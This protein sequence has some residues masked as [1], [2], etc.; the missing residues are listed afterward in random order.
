MAV[1]YHIH[2]KLFS[3]LHRDYR[4]FDQ[5]QQLIGFIRHKAFKLKE[6]IRVFQDDTLSEERLSIKARQILDFSAAY[7]VTDS[8]SGKSLGVLQ[9]KGFASLLRDTWI[10]TDAEGQP[11]GRVEE[12]SLGLALLRRFINLI[13]QA[14]KLVDED[15]LEVATF[16]QNWNIFV[17]KLTVVVSDKCR[18]PPV[19]VLAAGI[20]LIVIEGRQKS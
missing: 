4:I 10:V 18:L 6:D 8:R 15:G 7:D 13:P 16:R 19:L 5:D 14:F 17:P 3:F 9:R 1:E 12:D 11:A 20:V 2:S